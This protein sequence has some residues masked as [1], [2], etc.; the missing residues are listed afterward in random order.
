MGI[1]LI[2][3]INKKMNKITTTNHTI[4]VVVSVFWQSK[5]DK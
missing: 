1:D 5:F 2:D 3:K 4:I